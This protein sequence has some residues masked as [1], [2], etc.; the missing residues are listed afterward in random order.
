MSRINVPFVKVIHYADPFCPWSLA[1]EP[2]LR[3]IKE[4]YQDRIA[5]EYRMGGA[6]EE[7]TRWMG[8][9]GLDHEKAIELHRSIIQHTKMPFDVSFITK[10]RLK[11]SYPACRA[12]KAAQLKNEEKGVLYLRRLMDHVLV[13][14][15]EL[16]DD[17][18][19]KI[20]KEVGL[21]ST[22]VSDMNSAKV[23]NE[24]EKDLKAMREDGADFVCAIVVNAQGE[25]A[26]VEHAF[27]SRSLEETIER[28]VPGLPKYAPC[29]ISE[30]FEKHKGELIPAREIAVVYGITE[31]EA[32]RKLS[33]LKLRI[34]EYAGS[35]FWCKEG[36]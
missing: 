24:F 14:A 25:K 33:S 32:Q 27:D 5:I 2:A 35:R 6:V 12:V 28:M 19:T 30:Y 36:K 13:K 4:V 23:K 22:L 17:A 20:A 34:L 18:F 31:D 7:I 16:T 11:S 15:Q 29:E 9:M 10:T 1:S 8:E 21:S 3:R 26:I